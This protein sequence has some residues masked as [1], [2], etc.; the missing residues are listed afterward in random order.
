MRPGTPGFIGERLREAREARAMTALAL[1]DLVGVT[2]A[3]VSQYENGHQSPS[4]EIMRRLS[5]SLNVPVQRF[6]QAVRPIEYGTLFFRCMSSATKRAR[7]R[8]NRRYGWLRESVSFVEHYVRLP[9][10]RFPSFALP[11]NPAE[12]NDEC[13]EEVATG[14]RRFWGLQDGPISNVAW[15]L[16]N[17]GCIVSRFDLGAE[18]LDAFSEWH[19]NSPRPFIVVSSGKQSACRSRFDAAHELGHL[20]L[21]RHI[22]ESVFVQ[23]SSF[24][25]IEKQAHL[26]AAAFL[27]PAAS[28]S[29]AFYAPTL[30]SLVAMKGRWRVSIAAMI[31]RAAQLK[32]ISESQEKKL[33]MNL[34]RRKWRTRE[35]LDDTIEQEQPRFLK[36]CFDLLINKGVISA[37]EVPYQL[38]LSA[39]DI[40]QMTGIEAGTFESKSRQVELQGDTQA[41]PDDDAHIIRFPAML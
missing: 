29:K 22:P 15:L 21:H 19:L 14:A 34:G 17:N 41:E 28:F 35:P 3:A 37:C 9:E 8:A 32:L 39:S 7:L 33:W 16:E 11:N 30:D 10:V 31:M 36:K 5:K 4:P 24:G 38:G 18:T 20:L 40:E 25:L 26:F 23:H 13:I 6:I 12:L 1:A 27:L 2:R